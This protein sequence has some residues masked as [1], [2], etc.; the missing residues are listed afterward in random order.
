MTLLE[1]IDLLRALEKTHGNLPVTGEHGYPIYENW[2]RYNEKEH[3][4]EITYV[5]DG[6]E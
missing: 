4:I 3:R 6:D 2:V 1:L 5:W